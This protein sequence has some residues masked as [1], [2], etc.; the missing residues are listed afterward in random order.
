[1]RA[2]IVE[3]EYTPALVHE[4]DR[5]VVTAHDESTLGF[6]FLEVACRHKA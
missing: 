2:A 3:G 6:Q 4:K 5:A 1:M